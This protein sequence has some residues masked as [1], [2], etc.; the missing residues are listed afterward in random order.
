[1]AVFLRISENRQLLYVFQPY[2]KQLE[3]SDTL[4]LITTALI[5]LWN[6]FVH[7][8]THF[9]KLSE[10]ILFRTLGWYA[11]VAMILAATELSEPLIYGKIEL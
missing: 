7:T 1:M 6:I 2:F 3:V 10:I 9:V 8:L 11:H 4:Y 5:S